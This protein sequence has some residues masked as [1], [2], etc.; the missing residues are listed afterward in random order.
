MK[1]VDTNDDKYNTIGNMV[2]YCYRE[3]KLKEWSKRREEKGGKEEGSA[4]YVGSIER[5]CGTH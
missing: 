4:L 1:M 5:S 3:D 2:V